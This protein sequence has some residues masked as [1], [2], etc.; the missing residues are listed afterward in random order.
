[1]LMRMLYVFPNCLMNSVIV[2][3]SVRSSICWAGISLDLLAKYISFHYF[4]S[5]KSERF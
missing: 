1:M 3:T 5:H 4:A 2:T